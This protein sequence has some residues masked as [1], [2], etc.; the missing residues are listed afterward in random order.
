MEMTLKNLTDSDTIDHQDFLDRADILRALG[1]TVL[2]SNYAEYHRLAAYLFR[3]TKKMIGIVMGVPTLREIFDAKYYA[4]LEGGILESFGR[5]FKNDLKL[6]AYPLL[7]QGTG[8][9]ITAGNLRVE[10]HLR[11]LYA[12]LVENRLIESVRDYDER[13]LS[14]FSRDVLKRL[15]SGDEAWEAMVPPAV[16][17]VIKR[18][19]LLGYAGRAA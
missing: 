5:L 18:R 10:P 8:S 4:D 2:I 14:I 17:Q 11:H 9:L 19:Q 7:D 15:R 13:C 12:Y 6:Y 1:K 3:H 16:A